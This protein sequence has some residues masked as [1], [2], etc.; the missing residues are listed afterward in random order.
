[1]TTPSSFKKS[2]R[3]L[4]AA[5]AIGGTALLA[6]NVAN[7]QPAGAG[8]KAGHMDSARMEQMV[9]R[10]VERMA[11]DVNATPEQ[12]AKL[13]SIAKAA[14]ADIKP[15]HEQVRKRMEQA[16]TESESVL[17]PEQRAKWDA[18]MKERQE[19]KGHHMHDD[20]GG[21]PSKRD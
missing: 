11:K 12:K 5:L 19:H 1:M 15:L 8:A 13:L 21:R 17:T 9:E 10:H 16:K 7:A 20:K 18:K 4:T 3:L 14:Q 2:I 6:V